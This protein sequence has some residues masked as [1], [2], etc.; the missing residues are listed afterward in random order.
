M[1]G[2]RLALKIT[3]ILFLSYILTSC[4]NSNSKPAL[5]LAEIDVALP[6]KKRIVE[7]D[8]YTGRF[9]A[10][11][12]VDVRSRVT[13]Y[14]DAIKFKDGQLVKT[15]DVLFIIDPRPFEYAL[16]R[17]VAQFELAKKQYERAI[18][19][20][21]E[22]FIAAE[23]IDQRFQEMQVAQTRVDE[24]KLNL[25]FT[26]VKSPISGKVSRKY[27]SVGNLIRRNDTVLT[28]VV[29]M[30]PIY[31]YF[32]ASQNDLLKYIRL[33]KAGKRPDENSATPMVIKLQDETEYT[34][35]ATM[36]FFDNVV[37]VGT[38]TILGRA[39]VPNPEGLIY[40][41]LF[42]RARLTGS[43]EYDALLLPD[44]AINT[45]QTRKFVYVVD[46]DNKVQRVY[47]ELGPI[48][49]SSYYIIRKG[50]K[51][52]EKVVVNGIQRI[53]VP[54]QEVKPIMVQLHE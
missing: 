51:G 27:V 16:E 6:L 49:D 47:I 29:S 21:K 14:L 37:D 25:E 9:Q 43:G 45:D 35:Q 31:F 23:A 34:H 28:K 42:G 50:L 36:N 10:I 26:Q 13:G 54:G 44:T 39:T 2:T 33:A 3:I 40:P 46:K 24:A 48:R 30:D 18:K 41:G 32:E 38:G 8:E 17:A 22:S 12:E 20:K 15:G 11:E 1:K 53:H 4:G 52:D 7:W 5:P 19:L